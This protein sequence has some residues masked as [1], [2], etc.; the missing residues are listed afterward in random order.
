[1]SVVELGEVV[2]VRLDQ[3]S[4]DA[5]VLREVMEEMGRVVNRADCRRI[6]LNLSAVAR[7]PSLLLGKL[8]TWSRTMA[9]RHGK[10]L[11]CDVRPEVHAIFAKTRL[12]QILQIRAT[13]VDAV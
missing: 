1:L 4:F 9:D 5:L 10:L 11:L 3:D 8:L 12:D 7:L 6:V 13:E 2:L